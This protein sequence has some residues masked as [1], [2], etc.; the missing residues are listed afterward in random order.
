MSQRQC[1][2][3]GCFF[4][5]AFMVLR[6]DH[7]PLRPDP[8]RDHRLCCGDHLAVTVALT[9]DDAPGY[10]VHVNVITTTEALQRAEALE[11]VSG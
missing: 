1:W 8:D 2:R 5:A 11:R 6:R 4:A 3:K 7:D 9:D 10:T